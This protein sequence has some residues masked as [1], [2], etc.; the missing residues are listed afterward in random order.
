MIIKKNKSIEK[1]TK[2]ELEEYLELIHSTIIQL[3]KELNSTSKTKVNQARMRL[4]S[5]EQRQSELNNFCN[6]NL[7]GLTN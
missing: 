3:K 5:W 4:P 2:K 6:I 7:L 1:L